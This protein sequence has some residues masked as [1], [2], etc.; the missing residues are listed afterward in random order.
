M[1]KKEVI[2]IGSDHAG[3]KLKEKIKSFLEEL[4]YEYE[5]MG[6]FDDK[7]SDYPK[8]AFNVANKV[9]ENNWKGMLLCGSGTGEAIVANKVKG[10]RAANCFDE[11]TAKMSREHNNSNMLCL[12][13]RVVSEA[14]ARRITKA[15]LETEFSSE[16]RHKRRVKQISEIEG[17]TM[18]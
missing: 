13:A 18:K 3:F 9:S 7:P 12:G 17:K 5:D 15:W 6:A 8:T 1:S 10:V 4:G 16:S 2:V 14:E 11:Y